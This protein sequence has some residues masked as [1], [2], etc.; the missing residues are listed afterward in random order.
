MYRMNS[1]NATEAAVSAK[2]SPKICRHCFVDNPVPVSEWKDDVLLLRLDRLA[3]IERES[4]PEMLAC[5]SEVERRNLHLDLG[6]SSMYEYCVERL[7]WSDGSAMQRL[8]VAST[9][10]RYPKY[11]HFCGMG[12]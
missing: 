6:F 3:S 5:L 10:S 7:K 2:L 12:S 8:I 11:I 1:L 4:L 9:A